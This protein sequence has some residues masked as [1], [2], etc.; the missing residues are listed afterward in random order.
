MHTRAMP[1]RLLASSLSLILIACSTTRS[2]PPAPSGPENLARYVLVI[3][4]DSKGQAT[5]EWI[6]LRDVDLSQFQSALSS[7]SHHN[8]TLVPVST[9]AT[10]CDASYNR[11]IKFCFSAKVPIPIEDDVFDG[12]RSEWKR[13][14]KQWCGQT[15]MKYYNMCLRGVGPWATN[16]ATVRE[17]SRIDVAVDWLEQHHTEIIVGTVVVIAGVALVAAVCAGGGCVAL[18][19][20]VFFASEEHLT[21]DH[22]NTQA[23]WR[24][25]VDPRHCF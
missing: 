4:P 10:D 9:W 8:N 17:F 18:V 16:P 19:P 13:R 22:R 20:L 2:A 3:K 24:G 7:A 11:C 14:Q 25:H 5:H 1:Q 12:N 21:D 6:P 23:T 15:C